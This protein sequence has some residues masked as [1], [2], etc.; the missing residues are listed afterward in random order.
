MSSLSVTSALHQQ[1]VQQEVQPFTVDV[2]SF[3]CRCAILLIVHFPRPS[4]ATS[5]CSLL[6]GLFCSFAMGYTM[7]GLCQFQVLSPCF[8]SPG[9][10]F[11]SKLITDTRSKL[12]HTSFLS[13]ICINPCFK[14]AAQG[15]L[16]QADILDDVLSPPGDFIVTGCNRE[17]VNFVLHEI[18]VF[19]RI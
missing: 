6:C 7:L 18:F 16:L 11:T 3:T 12:F 1:G 17:P 8:S 19:F 5:L 9:L 14:M 10:I 2:L 15:L 13:Y 4:E